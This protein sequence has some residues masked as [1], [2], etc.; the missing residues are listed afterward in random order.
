MSTRDRYR[1]ACIIETIC[2]FL[3]SDIESIYIF[4][5]ASLDYIDFF[6]GITGI[7]KN[8][9]FISPISTNF[10]VMPNRRLEYFCY[11]LQKNISCCMSIR[12]IIFFEFIQIQKYNGI[13]CVFFCNAFYIVLVIETRKMIG[14]FYL[15]V[16]NLF[17]YAL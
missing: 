16:F 13:G 15:Y 17:F 12:V 3:S 14:I 4:L 5:Y 9:E 11:F 10:V 8:N 1:R 2:Y 7:Y 6:T